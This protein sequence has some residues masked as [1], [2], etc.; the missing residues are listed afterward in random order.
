[1][2]AGTIFVAKIPLRARAKDIWSHF[3]AFGSIKDIILPK[4]RDKNNRRIGFVIAKDGVDADKLIRA[5]KFSSF[6]GAWLDL[7][8]AGKQKREV[9]VNEL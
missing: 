9:V 2:I 8:M 3:S 6:M 4:K 1:M 7:K 5:T